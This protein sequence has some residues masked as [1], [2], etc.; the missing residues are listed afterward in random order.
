MA[1]GPIFPKEKGGIL[2][3]CDVCPNIRLIFKYTH[4]ET[5]LDIR[6]GN[7]PSCLLDA[8]DLAR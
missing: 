5:I 1:V 7:R 2:R 4:L 3:L 6:D 8:P